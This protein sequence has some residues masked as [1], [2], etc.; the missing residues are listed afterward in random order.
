MKRIVVI[1]VAG[2]VGLSF[3]GVLFGQTRLPSAAAAGFTRFEASEAP[4]AFRYP[5]DW[6]PVEQG[7]TVGIATSQ[8]LA[9]QL[10]ADN[11]QLQDG[12]VVFIVGVLPA[13]FLAF[14]GVATDEIDNLTQSLF[15][16][17]IADSE[18]VRGGEVEIY[19]IDDVEVGTVLFE[20]DE[21]DADGF[22]ALSV[23]DDQVIVFAVA[24]GATRDLAAARTTLAQVTASAEFTG[25]LEDFGF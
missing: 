3:T 13:A 11:P 21:I 20:T 24:A 10:E 22:F 14:M 8:D 19:S 25:S 23:L 4:I 16:N 9:A 6:F 12:D 5:S 1:V 7:E 15:D 2:L 18:E 17:M